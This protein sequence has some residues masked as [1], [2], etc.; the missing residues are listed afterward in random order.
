MQTER[1]TVE[2]SSFYVQHVPQYIGGKHCISAVTGSIDREFV[3]S[4]KKIR[5]F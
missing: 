1:L 2:Q 5:E 4:A 3:T